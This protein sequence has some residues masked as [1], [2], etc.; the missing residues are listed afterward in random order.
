MSYDLT[1]WRYKP[2]AA[3]NHEQVYEKLSEGQAVD[4]L[5]DLPIDRIIARLRNEFADWQRLD[6]RTF[7]GGD[8]GGFQITTT[9][10]C[11][12]VDCYGMDGDHMNCFIDVAGEFKCPLYDP[13]VGKRFGV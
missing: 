7:D 8:R 2:G 12:R 4:G 5:E 9:S 3:Q 13:Q 1:F 10:Q 11:L 6:D